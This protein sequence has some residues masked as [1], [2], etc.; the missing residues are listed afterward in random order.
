MGI[1]ID[2]GAINGERLQAEEGEQIWEEDDE[3]H[4]DRAYSKL[5]RH[6]DGHVLDIIR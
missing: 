1:C 3:I 4:I 5:M 6:S 2:S